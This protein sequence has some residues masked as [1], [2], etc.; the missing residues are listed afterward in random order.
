MLHVILEE[1][2]PNLS[3][4]NK[5]SDWVKENQD[6]LK[7]FLK[8]AESNDY[9]VGIASNQ[10]SR[11]GE[12]IKDRYAGIKIDGKWVI[13][14]DPKIIKTEGEPVEC[15]EGCLTWPGKTI[16][17]KRYPKIKVEFYTLE[18]KMHTRDVGNKFEA[19]VWQ[20]EINHLNGVEEQVFEDGFRTVRRTKPKV[21]R[22][23]PCPCGSNKKYKHCC[24]RK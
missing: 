11:D 20:H 19:Q 9:A 24:M 10:V 21:G 23:A 5:P 2:T 4:M 15:D 8:F 22:N 17:A 14:V 1:Q 16:V 7:E 18:G 13:A 12:R 6:D 3:P